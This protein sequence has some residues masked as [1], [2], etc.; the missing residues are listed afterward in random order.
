MVAFSGGKGIGGPQSSGLLAGKK[1]L[2]EAVWLN[3]LNLESPIAAIGRPMKVSKENIIGLVTALQ[4]FTDSD[5][6]AEWDGWVSKAKYVADRLSGIKGIR[7]EIEGAEEKRQGPQP[8]L[9]FEDDYDGPSVAEIKEQLENGDPGIYVGG[10]KRNE[11]AIVMVNV[12]D[13]EE[14]EIADRMDEILRDG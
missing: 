9:R 12:Q 5:E 1:E 14:I 7:V 6:T 4:L 3:S 10:G 8:I 11:I 2:M 13:G